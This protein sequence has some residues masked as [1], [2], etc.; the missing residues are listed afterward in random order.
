MESWKCKVSF[1]KGLFG[2]FV[3]S[4]KKE[5]H[6]ISYLPVADALMSEVQQKPG[7]LATR[8][9]VNLDTPSFVINLRFCK[10][11]YPPSNT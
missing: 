4:E 5:D 3:F 1:D 10:Y 2:G 8:L 6:E 11:A 9:W 7:T